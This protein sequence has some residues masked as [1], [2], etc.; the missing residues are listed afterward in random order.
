MG[1]TRNFHGKK[2]GPENFWGLKGGAPKNFRDEFFFASGP[3]YK[4][5]WT[6]PK[7]LKG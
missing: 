4:C 6:V 5:L 1:F 3:P 2:G 7:S